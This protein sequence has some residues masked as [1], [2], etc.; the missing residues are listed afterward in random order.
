MPMARAPEK[1]VTELSSICLRPGTSCSIVDMSERDF[2][3][4]AAKN[5]RGSWRNSSP[6]SNPDHSNSWMEPHARLP[7]VRARK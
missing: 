2:P 1:A 6:M 7:M 5:D 4:L 3:S